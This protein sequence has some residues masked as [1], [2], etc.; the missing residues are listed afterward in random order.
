MLVKLVSDMRNLGIDTEL[1]NA[2]SDEDL[3]RL[4]KKEKR[5]FITRNNRFSVKK[6]TIPIFIVYSDNNTSLFLFTNF[7]LS[8]KKKKYYNLILNKNLE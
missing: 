3:E 4:V 5:L 6:F 2:L 8:H 1:K 7:T